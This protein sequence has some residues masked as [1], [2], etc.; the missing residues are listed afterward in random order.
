[1]VERNYEYKE[2]E[3]VLEGAVGIIKLSE[4]FTMDDIKYTATAKAPFRRFN[5]SI[6][7]IT[8]REWEVKIHS[9]GVS[10]VDCYTVLKEDIFSE[11]TIEYNRSYD[12]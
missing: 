12:F 8:I 2:I 10:C 9:Q 7:E 4:N 5:V 3:D 1:M 6:E 11:P